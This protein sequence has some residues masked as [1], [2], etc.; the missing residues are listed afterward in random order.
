[1]KTDHLGPKADLFVAMS[2]NGAV[3]IEMNLLF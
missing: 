3:Y 1:M 2:S